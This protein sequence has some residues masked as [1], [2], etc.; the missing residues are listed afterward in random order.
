MNKMTNMGQQS[1][2]PPL[3]DSIQ[4]RAGEGYLNDCYT[5]PLHHYSLTQLDALAWGL[6]FS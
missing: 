4:E 3:T 6:F 1:V 2:S 5:I